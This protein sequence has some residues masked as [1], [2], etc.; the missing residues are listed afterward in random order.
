MLATIRTI[1]ALVLLASVGA[2]TGSIIST[3]NKSIEQY[4]H[5][6]LETDQK[7]NENISLI[8]DGQ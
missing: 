1:V 6:T 2:T 5:Y 7:A 3:H 8:F 4:A